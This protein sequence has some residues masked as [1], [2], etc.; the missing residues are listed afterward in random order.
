MDARVPPYELLLGLIAISYQLSLPI[1][2]A[3]VSI[4][5]IFL[6]DRKRHDAPIKSLGMSLNIKVNC[7]P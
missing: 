1:P 4:I 3:K 5:E 6:I 7:R 2:G